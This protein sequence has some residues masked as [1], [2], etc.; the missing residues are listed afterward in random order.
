MLQSMESQRV[1]H[2][3]ATKL[4]Q[5]PGYDDA[6]SLGTPLGELARLRIGSEGPT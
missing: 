3:G 5:F 2:N 6:S 1:R 4:N